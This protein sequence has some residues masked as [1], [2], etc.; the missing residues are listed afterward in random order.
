VDLNLSRARHP[1]L[2]AIVSLRWVPFVHTKITLDASTIRKRHF[3]I[4]SSHD[5]DRADAIRV[6]GDSHGGVVLQAHW[7]G[8]PRHFTLQLLRNDHFGM[9]SV[10]PDA[11]DALAAA[12]DV[13]DIR[14][15]TAEWPHRVA[16]RPGDRARK[17][18]RLTQRSVQ[19]RQ[20]VAA[21]LRSHAEFARNNDDLTGSPLAGMRFTSASIAAAMAAAYEPLMME[22]V[23]PITPAIPVLPVDETVDGATAV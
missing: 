9:S 15:E 20:S 3:L 14:D 22:P 10:S 6:I 2:A 5:L 23:V 16:A 7:E 13:I 11:L 19:G 8:T 21:L 17:P 12:V 18:T 4:T 1:Q